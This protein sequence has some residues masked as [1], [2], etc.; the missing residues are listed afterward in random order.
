MINCNLTINQHQCLGTTCRCRERNISSTQ[1]HCDKKTRSRS[2]SLVYPRDKKQSLLVREKKILSP[3]TLSI[4]ETRNSLL[5][6]RE[7]KTLSP[8]KHF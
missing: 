5:L 8:C 3:C 4:L 6:F 1:T 2:S 7:K